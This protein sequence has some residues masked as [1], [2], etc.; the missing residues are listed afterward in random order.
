MALVAVTG[1]HAQG[2]VTEELRI[3]MAAAGP[4][5]LEAILV[6]PSGPGR[7]PLAILSHGSPRE[8]KDRPGMSARG[9]LPEAIEFAR[10]GF[11]AVAVLRRGYGTSPGGWAEGFGSC[12]D[13]DYTKAGRAAAADLKASVAALTRRDDVDPRQVL[14]VGVSAGGFATVALT[15]DP[16]PGLVAAISFAGGRGSSAPDT[17]CNAESLDTAFRTFG[18]HSR[19]PMLWVYAI[20]DHFFGPAL[21]KQLFET[22]QAA[23]GHATFV[24]AVVFGSDGHGLFSAAGRPVWTPIVD[25]FLKSEH[26]GAPAQPLETP[27]LEAPGAL[28]ANG[29]KDFQTFLEAAF[30]KAFAVSD[31][32]AYAWRTARATT[33]DAIAA[34]LSQCEAAGHEACRLYAVDDAYAGRPD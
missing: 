3:P 16:P 18:A 24:R 20:N 27:A 31:K 17:V 21:A 4:E 22:F 10:R 12:A 32:G 5:G 1:V 23:G 6:K 30:H 11:V 34:A 14:A 29:R 25:A 13:A 28:G 2:L 7:H 15:D 26:L 8:A 19:V 33:A 9:M